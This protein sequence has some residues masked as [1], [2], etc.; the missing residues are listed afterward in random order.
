MRP[1]WMIVARAGLRAVAVVAAAAAVGHRPTTWRP[2]TAALWSTPR[3]RPF[4]L[5]T[6]KDQQPAASC[7]R[8]TSAS[9]GRFSPTLSPERRRPSAARCRRCCQVPVPPP[10]YSADAAPRR[11]GSGLFEC[12]GST[13]SRQRSPRTPCPRAQRCC[14]R[15]SAVRVRA[16]AH[17]EGDGSLRGETLIAPTTVGLEEAES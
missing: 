4:R 2:A 16:A 3:Q 9:S 7:A 11:G 10:L 6:A 5:P 15:R 13:D 14:G 12:M 17:A 1:T 8:R